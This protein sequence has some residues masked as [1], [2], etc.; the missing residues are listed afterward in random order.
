MLSAAYAKAR[1]T[2][3]AKTGKCPAGRTLLKLPGGGETCASPECVAACTKS[4]GLWCSAAKDPKGGAPQCCSVGGGFNSNTCRTNAGDPLPLSAPCPSGTRVAFDGGTLCTDPGCAD[5]CRNTKGA[6]CSKLGAQC[7]TWVYGPKSSGKCKPAGGAPQAC[8][9]PRLTRPLNPDGTCPAGYQRAKPG[10]TGIFMKNPPSDIC[11]QV[12]P[13]DTPAKPAKPAK[14]ARA[15]R[16]TASQTRLTVA[17]RPVCASVGCK[18]ECQKSNGQF[19]KAK[20]LDQKRKFF[21]CCNAKGQCSG[22]LQ[23]PGAKPAAP[24]PAKPAGP[25]TP[26]KPGQ[27]GQPGQPQAGKPGQP[28]QAGQP[29]AGIGPEWIT[30]PWFGG[31]GGSPFDIHCGDDGWVTKLAVGYDDAVQ[32]LKYISYQCND[33]R[34]DWHGQSKPRP[35]LF[36][37]AP[38]GTFWEGGYESKT[39]VQPAGFDSMWLITD[40][41]Q[42]K[43]DRVRAL[44][45]APN[46]VYGANNNKSGI[47]PYGTVLKN[48]QCQSQGKAAPGRK[49]RIYRIDGRT[50]RGVDGIRF[51]CRQQPQ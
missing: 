35:A 39:Y 1:Q 26:G 17:G 10:T 42:R 47:Y 2:S 20:V 50:G 48:F 14:P 34:A 11:R 27:P 9:T 29:G 12:C 30:S 24:A 28:G 40:W 19:C 15:P 49:Y 31:G 22:I 3:S 6:Y 46:N 5:V 25:G 51:Y 7:C 41:G 32:E 38:G 43:A 33:G 21:K 44:G 23:V 37:N 45:P 13:G 36:N 4:K 18:F 16:C 8:A